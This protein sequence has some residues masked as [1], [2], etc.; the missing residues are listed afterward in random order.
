MLRCLEFTGTELVMAHNLFSLIFAKR[1]AS[2]KSFPI[3]FTAAAQ[4]FISETLTLFNFSAFH[5]GM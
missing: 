5:K 4:F 2:Q 1:D 3:S